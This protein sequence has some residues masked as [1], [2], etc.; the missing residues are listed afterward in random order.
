MSNHNL[1]KI[2]SFNKV[3]ADDTT[4]D[5]SV[6][7]ENHRSLH[8]I[9]RIVIKSVD[10]PN[11]FYNINSYGYDIDNLGNN[12]Y[13]WIDTTSVLQTRV[14]PVGQ[15]NVTEFLTALNLLLPDHS[16]ALN[17]VTKKMVGTATSTIRFL[18]RTDGNLMAGALGIKTTS[19]APVLTYTAQHMPQ[20][21]GIESVY[22]LS[23]T[24][25]QSNLLSP[26][27]NTFPLLLHVPL[28]VPFGAIEHYVSPQDKLDSIT[29]PNYSNGISFR[30]LDIK[31]VD[32]YGHGLSLGGLDINIILKIYHNL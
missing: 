15:Y 29:Y 21:E 12:T 30:K 28:T 3:G 16:Y 20:L 25:G 5:F 4:D 23:N 10:I 18:N 11:V 19:I 26:N 7:F 1:C 27:S 13:R 17:P 31:V 22:I 32:K 6:N 8:Q 24:A 9:V 14:L 2:T